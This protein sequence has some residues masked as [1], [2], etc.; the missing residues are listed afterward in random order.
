MPSTKSWRKVN[1]KRVWLCKHGILL[2]NGYRIIPNELRGVGTLFPHLQALGHVGWVVAPSHHTSDTIAIFCI[3]FGRYPFKVQSNYRFVQEA[4][5]YLYL[6]FYHLL[7][8][9]VRYT[10]LYREERLA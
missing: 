5:R 1:R 4:L 3:Y 2:L 6:F 9:H 8:H 7:I 10:I